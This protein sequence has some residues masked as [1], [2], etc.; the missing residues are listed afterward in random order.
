MS[1]FELNHIY[2]KLIT[3]GTIVMFALYTINTLSCI[4][5]VLLYGKTVSR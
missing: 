4:F 2:I 3:D 1:N 5:I